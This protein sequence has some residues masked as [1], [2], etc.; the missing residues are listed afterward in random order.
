M[1]QGGNLTY[2]FV[3]STLQTWQTSN[4]ALNTFLIAILSTV[5][6]YQLA[7]IV[8]DLFLGLKPPCQTTASDVAILLLCEDC[9][10]INLLA[11]L[12]I[13]P[14][15]SCWK[16]HG[17]R[18]RIKNRCPCYAHCTQKNRSKLSRN[19]SRRSTKI[20]LKLSI[21]LAAA[22]LANLLAL[23][24][25]ADTDRKLTFN[26]VGFGGLAFGLNSNFSVANAQLKIAICNEYAM[27]LSDLETSVAEFYYCARPLATEVDTSVF[28]KA[29]FRLSYGMKRIGV[30]A[31]SE[32]VV[33]EFRQEPYVFAFD[34]HA[35]LRDENGNVWRVRTK[36]DDVSI[37]EQVFESGVKAFMGLCVG[38]S[39]EE[40]EKE[41]LLYTKEI[42]G[43]AW[44]FEWRVRC[45]YSQEIVKTVV[46]KEIFK[47]TLVE[48][49]VLEVVS[50]DAE[51]KVTDAGGFMFVKRRRTFASIGVLGICVAI[52]AVL[53]IVIGIVSRNDVH[54]G[55]EMLLKDT[56][57]L[58]R[59]DSM[60]QNANRVD[61]SERIYEG[62][63]EVGR[64]V[65]DAHKG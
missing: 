40:L 47:F 14:T 49:E 32:A 58:Q 17:F 38:K 3:N 18:S 45:A 55:I 61:Y 44:R 65:G 37:V 51:E 63:F 15:L 50:V 29:V 25:T 53:R 56:L 59:C 24:L 12:H 1:I 28:G 10:T 21:L 46:E 64:S 9:S 11:N 5:L 43:E 33:V 27:A 30:R 7:A 62:V 35:I 4:Q 57:R 34:L 23:L 16:F 26:D 2:P 41:S 52:V 8:F 54:L 48:S 39:V 22:P 31:P 13:F 42:A 20:L 19:S 60:L 36:I 6:S